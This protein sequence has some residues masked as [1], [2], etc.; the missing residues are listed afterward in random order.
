MVTRQ[1]AA[2]LLVSLAPRFGLDKVEVSGIPMRVYVNAPRSLRSL[3]PTQVIFIDGELPRTAT[4]KVL[5]RQLRD[6]FTGVSARSRA[7]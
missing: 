4:G 7:S 6:R 2:Q 1:E 3:L 5:K